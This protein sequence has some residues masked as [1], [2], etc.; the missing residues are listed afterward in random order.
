[1]NPKQVK[2]I[3]SKISRKFPEMSAARPKISQ[4]KSAHSSNFLLTFSGQAEGPGG[5]RI[6]RI[7][8]V[9]ASDTGKIIKVSTSKQIMLANRFIKQ[10]EL[11]FWRLV[12]GGLKISVPFTDVLR[13]QKILVASVDLQKRS[14][15]LQLSR[16]I[17][18]WLIGTAIGYWIFSQDG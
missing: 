5:K 1:M 17:S 9:V 11:S 12:V 6:N 10:I 2:S 14:Y 8:R 15:G 3:S 4:Q 18:A 13:K 16:A 7:V